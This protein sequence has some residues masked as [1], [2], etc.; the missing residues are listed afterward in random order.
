MHTIELRLHKKRDNYLYIYIHL[1]IPQCFPKD[2]SS[3][4]LPDLQEEKYTMS[5]SAE[6]Y[7]PPY[8]Y[9]VQ[10]PKKKK[11]MHEQLL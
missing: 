5:R 3:L 4:V 1:K 11:K 10:S 6:D 2:T 8:V 9:E 7:A